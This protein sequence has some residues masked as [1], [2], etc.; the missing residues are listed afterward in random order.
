[1]IYKKAQKDNSTKSRKLY[2]YKMK[3]LTKRNHI[4]EASKNSGVKNSNE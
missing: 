3:S 1:M 4:K 2:M